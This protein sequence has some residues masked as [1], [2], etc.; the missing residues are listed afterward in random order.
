MPSL[1]TSLGR[2][3]LPALVVATAVGGC[4]S[5]G[6]GGGTSS[7]SSGAGAAATASATSAG[8]T[9]TFSGGRLFD[10][11]S[12]LGDKA[13]RSAGLDPKTKAVDETQSDV[14]LVCH[15]KPTDSD[16]YLVSLLST[17][18][19]LAQGRDNATVTDYQDVKIGSR[20]GFT[21]V[22]IDPDHLRCYAAMPAAQG[23]FEVLVVWRADIKAGSGDLPPCKLAVKYASALESDLPK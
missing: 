21:A 17:S 1:A 3:V 23:M 13:L 22:A 5:G 12:D 15:W 4:S 7:T 19:T 18:R 6:S 16:K 9:S 14:W 20:S 10:P 2:R 8:P 11:C